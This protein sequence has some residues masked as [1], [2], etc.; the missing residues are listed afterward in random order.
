MISHTSPFVATPTNV[1]HSIRCG[2]P[3]TSCAGLT[4]VTPCIVSP[5]HH[6]SSASSR[7]PPT[8][9]TARHIGN[10]FLQPS[11][12][13]PHTAGQPLQSY[14][15]VIGSTAF[16]NIIA[17]R[18]GTAF[19][20][21]SWCVP[22]VPKQ[23]YSAVETSPSRHDRHTHLFSLESIQTRPAAIPSGP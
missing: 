2:A 13:H 15:T 4:P 1:L 3:A 10:H 19:F 14:S 9:L 22:L 6:L 23:A 5:T 17:I 12:N 11:V 16:W 21:Q 20:H 7:T 18:T 8:T